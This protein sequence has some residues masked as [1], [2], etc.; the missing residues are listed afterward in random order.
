MQSPSADP[1]LTSSNRTE[2]SLLVTVA[3]L[4]IIAIAGGWFAMRLSAAKNLERDATSKAR[5]WAIHISEDI[6]D[7]DGFLAGNPATEADFQLLNTTK[8]FGNVFSYKI[9]SA[10]G[11]VTRASNAGDLG[12]VKRAD[13][14]RDI[15]AAGETYSRIGEGG[16]EDVPDIYIEAYVPI[17]R[18]GRFLGTVETYVDVT[19]L[20]KDID[21]KTMLA[22]L[23]L[24]G[25]FI[26]FGTAL[27][28]V[29]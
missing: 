10:D 28:I 1:T 3:I 6:E 27:G 4:A 5:G 25:V 22:L 12:L 18:D 20:A 26:V 14:F 17:I 19:E 21:R 15:V 13:Y 9:Y 29:Y 7:F 23:G 11:T 8:N 16:F 2:K 24:I